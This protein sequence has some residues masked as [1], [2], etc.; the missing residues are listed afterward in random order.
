MN[1]PITNKAVEPASYFAGSP[2]SVVPEDIARRLELD[3]A[4]LMESL[5]HIIEDNS[6]YFPPGNPWG[7]QARA[8]LSTARANFP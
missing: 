3:R 5:D 2:A 7:D 6:Y 8:A 1:T 4:A